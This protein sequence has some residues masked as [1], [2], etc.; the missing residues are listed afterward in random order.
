MLTDDARR[1]NSDSGLQ[2]ESWLG[3]TVFFNCTFLNYYTLFSSLW[4]RSNSQNL[5][6][7]VLVSATNEEQ[8]LQSSKIDWKYWLI[9]SFTKL[10]R[11]GTMIHHFWGF[12]FG[13]ISPR[14]LRWGDYQWS[15]RK[16]WKEEPKAAVT[17]RFSV[18]GGKKPVASYETLALSDRGD[19]QD[20]MYMDIAGMCSLIHRPRK[21]KLNR[22]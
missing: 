20:R 14:W 18:A 5:H 17:D 9:W 21:S 10:F 4:V 15:R 11:K 16:G 13:R 7:V 2:T 22:V 12:R 8:N 19:T 3:L 6:T 1:L